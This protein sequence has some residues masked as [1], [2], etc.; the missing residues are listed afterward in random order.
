M[1]LIFRDQKCAAN[2]NIFANVLQE[3]NE[4][5]AADGQK[6]RITHSQ[7]KNKFEKLVLRMQISKFKPAA[8][9]WD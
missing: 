2:T 8:S 3:M 4:K 9:R 1:F 6:N 7:I 5:A